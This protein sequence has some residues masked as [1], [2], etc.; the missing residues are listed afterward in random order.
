VGELADD[1][2]LFEGELS[3]GWPNLLVTAGGALIGATV[4]ES[5]VA[6]DA[7]GAALA[8][9]AD[10]ARTVAVNTL[11]GEDRPLPDLRADEL[12]TALEAPLADGV[13]ASAPARPT[14]GR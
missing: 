7:L 14:A 11:V 10:E 13:I 8:F 2:R 3:E 4:R 9:D 1:P 12:G 5:L 6:D